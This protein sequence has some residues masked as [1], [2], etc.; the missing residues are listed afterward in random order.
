MRKWFILGFIAFSGCT[1][2]YPYLVV[3]DQCM[4]ELYVVH[5]PDAS[6]VYTFNAEYHID[7]GIT[8]RISLTIDNQSTDTLRFSQGYV[9]VESRNIPYQMNKKSIAIILPDA[10]PGTARTLAL[11]GRWENVD[12]EDPWLRIA[13]EELAITIKGLVEESRKVRSQE[14]RSIPRNPHLAQ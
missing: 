8:T 9:R 1:H 6:L 3:N 10:P 7:E 12:R 11:D 2:T 5:D 13:G 14:F 4:C